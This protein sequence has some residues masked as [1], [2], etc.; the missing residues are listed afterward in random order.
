MRQ[1]N[2]CQ[3]RLKNMSIV[4]LVPRPARGREGDARLPVGISRDRV[5]DCVPQRSRDH[6]LWGLGFEGWGVGLGF[7]VWG[8]GRMQGVRCRVQGEGCRVQGV[9]C[10]VQG[11]GCRVQGVGCRV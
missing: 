3:K 8:V 6:H 11:A 7:G 9:G 1:Q 10:R 4:E 2:A 5:Q